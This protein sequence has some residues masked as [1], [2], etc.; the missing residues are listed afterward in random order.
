VLTGTNGGKRRYSV[1]PVTEGARVRWLDPAGFELATSE[2]ILGEFDV[3]SIRDDYELRAT[4][5][6][7][8]VHRTFRAA[9]R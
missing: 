5:R 6:G 1:V 2:D 3:G 8:S 4:R 9:G 7:A